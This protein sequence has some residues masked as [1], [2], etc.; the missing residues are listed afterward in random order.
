MIKDT[1]QNFVKRYDRLSEV[2][3]GQHVGFKP[4]AVACKYY[5]K[6]I[7]VPVRHVASCT[8][9]GVLNTWNAIAFVSNDT[10]GRQ[11]TPR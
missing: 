10:S 8:V 3:H 2:T 11:S 5:T 7:I 4:T 9:V 1:V 6:R